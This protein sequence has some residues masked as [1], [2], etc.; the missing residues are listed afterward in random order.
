[1]KYREILLESFAIRVFFCSFCFFSY[2]HCLIHAQKLTCEET[3]PEPCTKE[4]VVNRKAYLLT[5]RAACV[6]EILS[7]RHFGFL[8]LIRELRPLLHEERKI[9]RRKVMYT[10]NSQS[11]LML[12]EYLYRW[13]CY[14]VILRGSALDFHWPT[15]FHGVAAHSHS[16]W[17]PPRRPT[18][19]ACT[20]SCS[21]MNVALPCR[22]KQFMR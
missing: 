20:P 16:R 6:L 17:S 11:Q 8:F 19:I 1:M 9:H 3:T 2:T 12:S 22:T 21:V 18:D 4:H 7:F 5:E 14:T 10:G 15:V 13:L